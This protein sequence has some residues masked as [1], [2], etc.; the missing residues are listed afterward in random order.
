M[1]FTGLPSALFYFVI[2]AIVLTGCA[3]KVTVQGEFP[4]PLVD[5]HDLRIG[6]VNNPR[7]QTF[8]YEEKSKDRLKWTIGTGGAQQK[9]LDTLLT[10][11]FREVTPL[12]DLPETNTPADVDLVILPR[13]R[14]FQYA[15]PR[16]T[17]VNIFEVWI[18]YSIQVYTNEGAM[19]ADWVMPAYGKT[20]TAFLKSED[21]ALNQAVIM[22]LR[23]AG[24]SFITGFER[25][26][27][28][29]AWLDTPRQ[30]KAPLPAN[31]NAPQESAE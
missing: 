27:E 25:V 18:K 21:D 10:A 7:F 9:L 22:A 19:L 3:G 20:P 12:A 13:I 11:M 14:E 30:A 31:D 6:V 5:Q 17:K 26:P 16:E 29:R 23:D 24:A 2:G 8:Q 4:T 28:I 1:T 15:M